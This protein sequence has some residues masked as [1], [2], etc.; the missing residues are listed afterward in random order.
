MVADDEV[1][2]LEAELEPTVGRPAA[3]LVEVAVARVEE[4]RVVR[5]VELDV[6]CAEPNELVHLL[7]QDLRHV[8]EVLLQRRVG[9][10][11]AIRVPEVRE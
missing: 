7:A 6:A 1:V 4:E 3:A 8:A 11:R 9:L 2:E 5:R 10:R